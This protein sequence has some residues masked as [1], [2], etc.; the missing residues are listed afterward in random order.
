MLK[1]KNLN[2]GYNSRFVLQDINLEIKKGEI[3]G[4]IGPNGAGKTTLIRAISRIIKPSDGK[5]FLEGED[6]WKIDL[7]SFFQKVA[8]VSP[9]I[10]FR[11]MKV[12]E[13]VLLGRIPHYQKFQLLES[14]KDLAILEESLR[15]TQ[16]VK[17]RNRFLS[18]LSSGERQLVFIAQALAQKPKLLI[19]DEPITHLDIAHQ[20]EILELL[21]KL[22]QDLELT[23]IMVLHNLNLASEYCQRLALFNQGRLYKVGSPYEVLD[24]KIIE[25]VYKTWV[26]VNKNPLTSKPYIFLVPHKERR[27]NERPN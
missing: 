9:N 20:I 13:F 10:E 3:L 27:K 25:E 16:T 5:I 6:I 26:I 2:C 15:L 12:E 21:A 11:F 7:R 22:N 1:I 14:E 23:I 24:Y 8:V 17:F 4:I 19:L 18:E